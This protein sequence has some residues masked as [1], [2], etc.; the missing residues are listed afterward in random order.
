M[1]LNT[2]DLAQ[3]QRTLKT[4]AMAVAFVGMMFVPQAFAQEFGGT[5]KKVCGFF[6]SVKGLLNLVSIAVVTIAVIFAGYQIAFAH[7][8]ISDVAPI[9][10]GGFVIG[11][12]AQLA[13]MIIPESVGSG[14]MLTV[15]SSAY[16]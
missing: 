7:K 10:I 9:M 2:H 3:A 11:A 15:L 4:L 13:K 12:A 6:D 14:V 1:K 5:D 8:R 16:A